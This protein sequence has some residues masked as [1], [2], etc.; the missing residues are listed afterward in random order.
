MDRSPHD[1]LRDSAIAAH[2][3][4][5]RPAWLFASDGSRL[6]FANEAG[7]ALLG[8]TDRTDAARFTVPPELAARIARSAATLRPDGHPR[9]ERLRGLGS[10]FGQPLTCTCARIERTD[11]AAILVA[12]TETAGPVHSLGERARY[13]IE[14]D[15]AAAAFSA[16]GSLL[17]ATADALRLIDKSASLGDLGDGVETLR[18]GSGGDTMV[19]AFFPANW[20]P[21][22]PEP[23]GAVT[24]QDL[25]DLSP[26]AE[27]I[28]A[29]TRV[30]PQRSGQDGAPHDDVAP[31]DVAD[32]GRPSAAHRHPT[33]FVWETDAEN[34]F[35][36]SGDA[37]IERAGPRTSNL[38]G[39]FWGEIAAK[40]ALDPDGRVSNA[41]VSRA[42]WSAHW[43]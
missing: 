38:L 27:A 35:T 42:T 39:R 31:H 4:G 5:V 40:L 43:M 30:P 1:I 6:I 37:F 3:S 34:R 14:G 7:A 21:I 29:M 18:V 8:L 36:I 15:G 32:D 25:L 10:T 9:L 19:L 17:H 11:G 13:L 2:A 23:V 16:D 28:T 41:L 26:I 20:Q 33:R 12:A 22:A 24:Q